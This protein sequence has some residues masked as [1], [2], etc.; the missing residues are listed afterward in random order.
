MLGNTTSQQKKK[1]K[2]SAVLS[3]LPSEKGQLRKCGLESETSEVCSLEMLFVYDIGYDKFIN[4][5]TQST[6][7]IGCLCFRRDQLNQMQ[8][9]ADEFFDQASGAMDSTSTVYPMFCK[10]DINL[11]KQYILVYSIQLHL[12]YLLNVF[13]L[14]PRTQQS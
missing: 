14:F 4:V 13:L 11:Q 2:N 1:K 7:G 9:K 8:V 6:I 10:P 12:A 3:K 5:E